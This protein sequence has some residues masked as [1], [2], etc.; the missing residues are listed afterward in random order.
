MEENTET[1]ATINLENMNEKMK[2]LYCKVRQGVN[3]AFGITADKL[4][5]AADKFHDTAEILREKDI[6][7]LKH[8][9]KNMVK[10]YPAVSLL[11]AAFVGLI[12]GKIISK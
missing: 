12:F 9:V 8:D 5:D 1:T 6:R 3:D 11:A 7:T 4:D 2:H 10:N